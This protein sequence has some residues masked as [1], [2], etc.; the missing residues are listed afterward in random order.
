[1]FNKVKSMK[2]SDYIEVKKE[3]YTH[4]QV[5]PSKSCKNTSTDKILVLVNTMYRKL[6]KLVKIENKKLVIQSKLK[7]SYYI[8]ITKDST[9]FYFIVP[10]CFYNQVK[11]KLSETWKNIEIKKVD[12]LPININKCTKY[13][14]QYKLNDVLSLNVD[15]RS[16]SLLNANLSILE[17]LQSNESVGIFYNFMPLSEKEQ[18]YFKISSKQALDN[19][20]KGINLKKV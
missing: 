11:T 1:M 8:H 17:I 20:K 9:E 15:K 14:L 7:L 19:F 2:F 6:D 12:V 3:E 16:N 13:Q 18:N 4:I 5:I 10:S